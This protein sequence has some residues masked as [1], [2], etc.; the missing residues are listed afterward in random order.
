MKT[1]HLFKTLA[2]AGIMLLFISI[3]PIQLT[4]QEVDESHTLTQSEKQ[5][6]VDSI[7]K[8]MREKYVFPDKGNEMGE[9][10]LNN[11]KAGSYDGISDPRKFAD[12]LSEDLLTINNDRHIGVRYMP[13]RIALMKKSETDENNKEL[14]ELEKREREFSNF[15]FKE[16]D[17]LPGNV[18]YLK[19]NSFMDASVAGATAVAAMNFLTHTDALIVDLTDNGG[20]SPSLIQ[21]ITTYFFEDTEH[22]NSFYIRE[23]DKMEQF[24]TLTYVPGEKLL[25][26]DI[27][28]L[29]SSRTFSG[30]E[31]FTYNL[32][33]LKRAVIVGE[34]TGGGAHPVAG[35]IINDN[36]IVRVPYGRAINPIT[37]TNWEGTGIKPDIEVSKQLAKETAYKMALDSLVKK[38]QN[39]E[40]K[41]LLAWASKGLQAKLSPIIIDEKSIKTY[42]GNYGPRKI[43]YANGE[44]YYQ[45][46]DGPKMKM[47]P[48]SK[49]LFMFEEIDYF[50]LQIIVENG[51]AI[52]V[53]GHYDNGSTDRHDRS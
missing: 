9:L 2:F 38:E 4:A 32:K 19:F 3:D 44:L 51:K 35:H 45:R 8:F 24:W 17:I 39:E 5:Q 34:T 13:E 37:N 20:G 50:R 11:F 16:I 10:V 29:T 41:N 49:D 26:T 46:D 48:M 25:N 12:V 43:T 7:A 31:E 28:V 22:L 40:I 53:E 27:Y 47:I 1:L 14:E 15:N 52:A 36:F 30:A 23:G 21:L 42:T 6:V 18:G 33:N